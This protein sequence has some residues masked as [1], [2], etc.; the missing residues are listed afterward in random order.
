L[1]ASS[2]NS[3]KMTDKVSKLIVNF[4]NVLKENELEKFIEK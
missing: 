4:K 2:E 1:K 3:L